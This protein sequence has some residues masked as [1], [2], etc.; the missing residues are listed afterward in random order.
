I[1][2]L[3][4]LLLQSSCRGWIEKPIV[5]DTG[6]AIPRREALRVTKSDGTVIFLTDSFITSDSIVG[7][8]AAIPHRRTAIARAD[9]TKIQ[10][11]VDTTPRGVR[12]AEKIYLG[13]VLVAMTA[14]LV[15][16]FMYGIA[17]SRQ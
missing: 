1:L 8:L 10:G 12:I 15:T 14:L 5:P 4:G 16:G 2:L 13:A 9:V 11:R 3:S 17:A 7:L 6:I